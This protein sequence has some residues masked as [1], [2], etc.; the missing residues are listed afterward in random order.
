MI[1]DVDQ[2]YGNCPQYIHRRHIT[3]GGEPLNLARTVRYDGKRLRGSDIRLIESADT[4]F[5]GTT[6]PGG[7]RC[8]APRRTSRLR[9]RHRRTALGGRTI[10][11]TNMFNS[12]G[13]LAVDPTAALLFVDFAPVTPAAVRHGHRGLGRAGRG[14]TTKPDAESCSHR[15]RSWPPSRTSQVRHAPVSTNSKGTACLT[16]ARR[17][18]RSTGQRGTESASGRRRLERRTP[19]R[20]PRHTPDSAWRN[21]DQFLTGRAAIVEFLTAKWERGTR[22]RAAKEPVGIPRQPHGGAVPVRMARRRRPVVPKLRQRTLGIRR[23]RPDM[24]RREASINDVTI[25][26]ADRRYFGPARRSGAG[27][28]HPPAVTRPS[29]QPGEWWD[30]PVPSDRLPGPRNPVEPRSWLL[31]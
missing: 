10:R 24:R 14:M 21:R 6:T 1:L 2:A 28:R 19:P 31:I 26:E 16:S 11:A 18:R 17:C 5:L 15:D 30:P 3:V 9:P 20:Q 23:Q 4:F 22:L 25:T 7:Q 8:I 27:T 29:P 12:F 13:N